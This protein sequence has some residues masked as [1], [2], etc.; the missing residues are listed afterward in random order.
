[1]WGPLPAADPDPVVIREIL[2]YLNF[3]GGSSD[4]KFQ[5]NLNRVAQLL[6]PEQD[7]IPLE[8]LLFRE[9]GDKGASEKAFEDSSQARAVIRLVFSEVL[10]GYRRHHR[11][12]L[13]HVPVG[14]FYHPFFVARAC[15]A[16]LVQG[17]PWGET[18]RIV[19]GALACLND[20]LGHRPVAVLE[21]RRRME[22]YPHER[23]RPVPLFLKS[24]GVAHGPY[25][26]LVTRTLEIIKTLP[27]GMCHEAHFQLD[28]MDELALDLRAYDN[29]HPVYRRTNYLF[30][31]WDPHCLDVSGRYRRFVVREVILAALQ[32]WIDES[33]PVPLE[34]RRNEAAA[35]LAG[36]MLMAS[37]I[38]GSGPDTHSSAISLT[39][40][41][42]KVA[43]QRDA[44]Y[45]QLLR[46]MTGKH[47]ERLRREAKVVQQPF[48]KIRQH[49]N[50]FLAN[51][52]CQQ[53]QRSHLSWLYSRMGYGDSAR[54]QARIIPAVSSRFESEI[55]L[56]ISEAQ[57][58]LQDPDLQAAFSAIR[59]AEDLLHRGIECGALVDPWNILG[60]Q[61]QYPLFNSREDA[62]PDHRVDRLLI[63]LEQLFKVLGRL[64]SE[65]AALGQADLVVE[66]L[67]QF[68]ALAG[69]WDQFASTVVTDLHPVHGGVEVDAARRVS[70]VLLAWHSAGESAGNVG[71]WKQH[72][73]D[74]DTPIAYGTVIDLLL[75]KRDLVASM[76]LLIQWLSQG[77]TVPLQQGSC[78]FRVL[79]DCWLELATG[80][81]G[82]QT[83]QQLWSRIRTFFERIEANAGDWGVAP[84][85]TEGP[86]GKLKIS[87]SAVTGLEHPLTATSFDP[88][89]LPG[90]DPDAPENVFGAAY[91]G[92]VFRDSANDGQAGDTAD[93][94]PRAV[95]TDLDLLVGPLERRVRFLATVSRGWT[96][97]ARWAV[98]KLP[99]AEGGPEDQERRRVLDGWRRQ[100][101]LW[102]AALVQLVERLNEWNPAAPG[103]DPD[104]LSDYDRELHI[105]HS[106]LGTAVNV[107]VELQENS[108]VLR[109]LCTDIAELKP[110]APFEEQLLSLLACLSRRKVADVKRQVGPVLKQLARLPL[111]YTPLDRGGRVRDLL[112]ARNLQ[113]VL[114]TLLGQ[115]PTLG[116]F[117]ESWNV[118][119]T[120][121]EM[122]RSHT[123][124]GMS[125]TE[126]DRLLE[127]GLSSLLNVVL[128]ASRRW[129]AA[130]RTD[131]RLNQLF[132]AITEPY[133][134]LWM[135]H[136]GTMRLSTVEWLNDRETWR[137][138]KLFI[139]SYGADL[140][141]PRML[142]MGN[143]RAIV[144]RGAEEY[145]AY[146]EESA[147]PLHPIRLLKD[148]DYVV[149]RRQAAEM[150]EMILRIVVEKF[151]RFLEYNST[152]THS[153]YGD[154]LHCL[155]DFIRLEADYDRYDWN[156]QPVQIAHDVL[157]RAGLVGTAR[158][159]QKSVER[160]TLGVSKIF[161]DKLRRLEK[162]HGM[163]LPSV[164][165]RLGERFVKPLQLDSILA[166]VRPS[167]FERRRGSPPVAFPQLESLVD[168]YLGT[169]QGSALDVQPW[170]HSL[171]EEVDIIDEAL[172]TPLPIRDEEETEAFV[173][174][175]PVEIAAQLAKWRKSVP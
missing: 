41:L 127:H 164:T 4:T 6:Q 143:L 169:T 1:V 140:F 8:D 70:R 171:T 48:G 69:W 123:P 31:E 77:D 154:Q 174:M 116:L 128:S 55:Q 95:E 101:D 121:Y 91:E 38:S 104:S 151:D 29:S 162:Q 11:D 18:E 15:E 44:F 33:T 157:V 124:G 161:L 35:V 152:T 68:D 126:F 30:G 5:A 71:F 139:G 83:H 146:L 117:Q 21:N 108:R 87:G 135:K 160:N 159:W 52:G 166:L 167:M 107:V 100:N 130:D 62:V 49:L 12:L 98:A 93:D 110:N 99:I 3:S 142:S 40:L 80:E 24:V 16:T 43:R 153:D 39:T 54:K 141:H 125:I 64:V 20:F 26:E 14:W 58:L 97:A 119:R 37:A 78:D 59:Q 34:E 155:L 28:L 74:L 175:T 112:A 133:M 147:D 105:K 131:R 72:L 25:S 67:K 138:V 88:F 42:P 84:Q 50:L 92:V 102:G 7:R 79:F 170:M 165:D 115:L 109:V 137:E 85:L 89:E 148:I 106:L 47:A 150:L 13:G 66:V 82:D 168:D 45:E 86:H 173:A 73:A 2:G 111:L 145:L 65:A 63:L 158:L 103:G 114:R 53:L 90:G 27:S 129:K 144:Q 60:F 51:H 94:G 120:A 81:A 172:E 36:T 9:L 23:F 96:Q 113:G 75:R 134:E 22:P 156:L 10:P 57:I 19:S 132:T 122:E 17:P 118:L 149:S 136:S 32:G 56:H 61:A 163:R 76:N 46:S